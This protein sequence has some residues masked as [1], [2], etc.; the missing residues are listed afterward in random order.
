MSDSP[1]QRNLTKIQ[2]TFGRTAATI[3]AMP[4]ESD[5]LVDAV[6]RYEQALPDTF[7]LVHLGL[8]LDG[9]TASLFPN[10]AVLDVSDRDVALCGPRRG[11]KQMTLTYRGLSKAAEV[12]WL[13]TGPAKSAPLA[14]LSAN[15]FGIPAGRITGERVRVVADDAAANG[16]KEHTPPGVYLWHRDVP[17]PSGVSTERQSI[18]RHRCD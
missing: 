6:A 1:K 12:L 17:R 18:P 9:H 5:N 15:D 4:V 2:A 8:G 16:L 13:I 14:R 10:D 3:L 11:L 7:D